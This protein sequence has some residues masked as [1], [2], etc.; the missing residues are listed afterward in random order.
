MSQ[1][2]QIYKLLCETPSDI[3]EHLPT[4]YKYARECKHITEMGVRWVVSTWAFLATEP[5][6]MISYDIRN[7]SEWGV[8]ILDVLKLARDEDI[9]YIFIQ[10]DVLK[11]EIEKT[12]L[13]FLDTVHN[14]AQL[15]E[16]LRLHAHKVRK[17]II[18]HDTVTYG[19][20][21]ESSDEPN[22]KGIGLA[23]TEF[24]SEN[25]D[26]Y[27]REQFINNNGLIVIARTQ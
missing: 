10:D 17:Y 7:P 3:N 2:Y 23:I 14:Y 25:S 18:F 19:F 5:K 4:L 13:L 21:D 8:D 11:V 22:S 12:D 15:K 6:K 16:E 9:N 27:L 26:W 1:I 20:V 24:L